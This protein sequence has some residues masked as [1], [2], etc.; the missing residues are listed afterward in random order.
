[1]KTIDKFATEYAQDKYLPVQTYQAVEAGA[2]YVLG[3][4]EKECRRIALQSK[5]HVKN[6]V[7]EEDKVD[8]WARLDEMEYMLKFIEEL[9][10]K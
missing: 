8:S 5:S 6:P 7:D 10:K 9:K 1:M 4:I 3:E 2:N